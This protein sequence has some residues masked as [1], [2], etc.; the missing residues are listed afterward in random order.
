MVTVAGPERP[1]LSSGPLTVRGRGAGSIAI[2]E[3][4]DVIYS[5]PLHPPPLWVSVGRHTE[6]ASRCSPG[7]GLNAQTLIGNPG[8]LNQLADQ[9]FP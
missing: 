8:R 5:G 4:R 7:A 2:E 3:D 1:A 9:G 6:H